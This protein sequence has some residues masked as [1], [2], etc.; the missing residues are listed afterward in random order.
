MNDETAF[1]LRTLKDDDG[2]YLWNSNND[3]I[4]GKEV[5]TSPYMP[6]IES[7]KQPIIFGDLSFYWVIERK[8]LA[9]QVLNE[10]YSNQ[11][12]IGFI[13]FERV[14]GKLIRP[15]AVKTIKMA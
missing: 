1:Y 13:G 15:E 12:Q 7:G 5:I 8:P 2:N 11:G 4:F 3:T 9:I 14:D 6:S 10:L